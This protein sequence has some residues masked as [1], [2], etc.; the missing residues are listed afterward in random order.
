[1]I[2]DFDES[3]IIMVKRFEFLKIRPWTS[4]VRTDGLCTCACYVYS[5]VVCCDVCVCVWQ[6]DTTWGTS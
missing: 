6:C 5:T 1:V 2:N 4:T 3:I